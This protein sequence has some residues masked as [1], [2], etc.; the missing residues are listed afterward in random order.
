[1]GVRKLSLSKE[2]LTELYEN[3]KLT[4]YQIAERYK[5]DRSTICNWLVKFSIMA[6]N[7]RQQIDANNR[8]GISDLQR[9][10]LIGSLLGDGCIDKKD[11]RP[12]ARYI[13]SHSLKQK[14]YMEWI[15]CVLDPLSSDISWYKAH[16]KQVN[17]TYDF[18]NL[19]TMGHEYFLELRDLFYDG[20][21]KIIRAELGTLMTHP[22][23][24]AV[25]VMDDGCLVRES[26]RIILCTDCFTYDEH[27][28][29]I[30]LLND[31]F[32]LSAKIY[33]Y[34]HKY[35]RIRFGQK[36]SRKLSNIIRPF[37]IES[38]KYKLVE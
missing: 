16:N 13:T 3:Q 27:T 20:R 36:D 37:V 9:A 24:L 32:G 28:I 15:K 26:N 34:N 14:D 21:K 12:S 25:W 29:L 38:M 30:K 22:L 31:N 6:R 18:G 10:F 1:M 4:T 17:K 33:E 19:H 35:F 8:I 5:V 11:N 7:K 23:S 2:E